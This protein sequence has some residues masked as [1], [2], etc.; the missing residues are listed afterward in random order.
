MSDF[1]SS[2]ENTF[3]EEC[4]SWLIPCKLESDH[5]RKSGVVQSLNR[6]EVMMRESLTASLLKQ[7]VLCRMSKGIIRITYS[8]GF[9]W[10]KM[11]LPYE[12]F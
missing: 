7:K 6:A 10:S 8:I 4:F 11:M 9:P 3:F 5:L 2:L 12:L 1:S